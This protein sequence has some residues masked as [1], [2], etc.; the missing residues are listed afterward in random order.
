MVDA[1]P[2]FREFGPG[3][4]T[5]SGTMTGCAVCATAAVLRRFGKPI[6][7]MTDP[8]DGDPVFDARTLGKS[9]GARHRAVAAAGTSGDRHGLSLLGYCTGGTNWCAYC[10]VLELRARGIP[11]TFQRPSDS[12]I[13]SLL[14]A[15]RPLVV[16]GLYSRIPLVKTSSYS[17]SKP[18]HGRSDTGFGGWHMV[19]VWRV[20][21]SSTGKPLAVIV[22]DAD[23]GSSSRP[24]VPPHSIWTWSQ[25]LSYYHA[26]GSTTSSRWG[27]AVVSSAPP[28]IAP[29]APSTEIPD[30]IYK[31]VIFRATNL[32]SRVD[33]T[34]IGTVTNATYLAKVVQ[35]KDRRWWKIVSGKRTGQA[36]KPN[37]DA[38]R[39]TAA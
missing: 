28:A 37:D 7:M 30:Q 20:D 33:G 29:P 21:L 14:K 26:T 8:R 2:V 19:T 39:R 38:M 36:F 10:A 31:V 13:L 16:P 11:T 12:A 4:C 1:Y 6:P 35:G 34:R 3:A 18:A 25:F 9:M 32:Y 27:M 17:S 24:V 5:C 23:F 22:S 15:R